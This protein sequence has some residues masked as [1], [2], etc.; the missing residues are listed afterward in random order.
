MARRP[1]ATTAA[2]CCACLLFSW[3]LSLL[4]KSIF[5]ASYWITYDC[6]ACA[7]ALRA[8][9]M[10]VIWLR[11]SRADQRVQIAPFLDLSI[12][13]GRRCVL[14][15]VLRVML[16]GPVVRV[17]SGL[18]FYRVISNVC[19]CVCVCVQTLASRT[20]STRTRRCAPGVARLRTRRP[21]S[22]RASSTTRRASTS[23]YAYRAAHCLRFALHLQLQLLPPPHVFFSLVSLPLAAH[24]CTRRPGRYVCWANA[25]RRLDST[26]RRLRLPEQR[27][28]ESSRVESSRVELRSAATGAHVLLPG[29]CF[30]CSSRQ[31]P[32]LLTGY[33]SAS[34]DAQLSRFV[35]CCPSRDCWRWCTRSPRLHLP[36]YLPPLWTIA[37]T[38]SYCLPVYILFIRNVLGRP[39]NQ[40]SLMIYFPFSH[41]HPLCPGPRFLNI[42]FPIAVIVEYSVGLVHALPARPR[43]HA[44]N[45]AI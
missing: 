31:T 20:R 36:I 45:R 4:N 8:Y 26:R 42:Y 38:S 25:R 30:R 35:M 15:C 27:T 13:R 23:G 14:L 1:A 2:L 37:A 22:S 5:C 10:F 19:V 21:S 3:V 11:S 6:C 12:Q 40:R 41:V 39:C 43:P 34:G 9:H 24:E 18:I 7:Q 44:C 32:L 28:A 33:A 29:N 17:E 16:D